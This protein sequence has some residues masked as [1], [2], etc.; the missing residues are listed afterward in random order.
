MIE[1]GFSL[2]DR[3]VIVVQ[4]IVIIK[5]LFEPWNVVENIESSCQVCTSCDHSEERQQG[6]ARVHVKEK[7]TVGDAWDFATTKKREIRVFKRFR[8]VQ[9]F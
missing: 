8:K 4:S 7:A 1:K 3:V 6:S 9:C 2:P 5:S